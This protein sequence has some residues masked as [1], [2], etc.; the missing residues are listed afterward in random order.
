[1][2][3]PL[4]FSGL[5]FLAQ[6]ASSLSCISFTYMTWALNEVSTNQEIRPVCVRVGL[7]FEGTG[8]FSL[9]RIGSISSP[10]IGS[11]LSEQRL[12]ASAQCGIK[13]HPTLAS[14]K[15]VGYHDRI[16]TFF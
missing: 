12:H 11:F 14:G 10:R 3:F 2:L 5:L 15:N 7:L 1:V 16:I 4:D 13:T 9:E 8:S 6:R